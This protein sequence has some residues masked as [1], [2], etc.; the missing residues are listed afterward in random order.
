MQYVVKFNAGMLKIEANI[1]LHNVKYRKV[2]PH[3]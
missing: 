2:Y 3:G 1:I